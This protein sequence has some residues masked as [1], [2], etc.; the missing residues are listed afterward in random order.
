MVPPALPV[1]WGS[2]WNM[3]QA[4]PP[5]GLGTVRAGDLVVVDLPYA[6]RGQGGAGVAGQGD[7]D[8]AVGVVG[9]Q[10]RVLQAEI[11][12]EVGDLGA[13]PT[14]EDQGAGDGRDQDVVVAGSAQ[15]GGDHRT[16]D[17]VDPADLPDGLAGG[18]VEDP[19]RPP[20]DV[21][22]GPL[23][24]LEGSVPEDVGQGRGR[25]GAAV[26]GGRPLELAA[27]VVGL[28]RVGVR[29]TGEEAAGTHH[30][31]RG[32][33]GQEPAHGRRRVDRSGWCRPGRSGCPGRSGS[34]GGHRC[35]TAGRRPGRPSG[36][37]RR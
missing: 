22:I 26:Q 21:E 37:R 2:W 33:S 11:G 3:G 10:G 16:D 31:A 18:R 27:V 28:H 15:V 9:D 24:H 7:P 8:R 36:R 13:G 20:E 17:P 4:A 14:V 35:R 25:E 6:R 34:A 12:A 30:D 1:S 19:D 29:G 32:P 23:H 5:D